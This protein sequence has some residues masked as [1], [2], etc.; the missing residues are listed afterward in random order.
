VSFEETLVCDGCSS[1][2]DGGSRKNTLLTLRANGGRAFDK[3][4]SGNGWSERSPEEPWASTRRHLCGGCVRRGVDR[5]YDLSAIP[6]IR[7]RDGT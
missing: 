4:W 2:L 7:E 6:P 5:F 1:V 3:H